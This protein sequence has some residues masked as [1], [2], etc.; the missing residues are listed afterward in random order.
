M[1][2][3]SLKLG[4]IMEIKVN[5]CS[6]RLVDSSTPLSSHQIHSPLFQNSDFSI[7]TTD[8]NKSESCLHCLWECLKS[9]LSWICCCSTSSEGTK[10]KPISEPLKLAATDPVAIAE[11][12]LFELL[13]QIK[14]AT[15]IT[16]GPGPITPR[17]T[18]SVAFLVIQSPARDR[19]TYFITTF[20]PNTADMNQVNATIREFFTKTYNERDYPL[21]GATLKAGFIG[22][23]GET[24]T[25]CTYR[26]FSH[27]LHRRI[28]NMSESG[29]GRARIEP[30]KN[31]AKTIPTLLAQD[32]GEEN[33]SKL[34]KTEGDSWKII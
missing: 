7:S 8:A 29:Q 22:D 12:T 2:T 17:F 5:Q 19:R 3:Y 21:D 33:V 25:T 11:P 32:V 23:P 9:F 28:G 26:T 30:E 31:D 27:T 6:S 10:S 18:K 24:F 14:E 4:K 16:N 13:N 20:S 15:Q 34:I 1:I